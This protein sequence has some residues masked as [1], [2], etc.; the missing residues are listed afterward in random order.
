MDD[1][2]GRINL[3][4]ADRLRQLNARSNLAG[5]LQTSSHILAIAST[6][7]GLHLTWGTWWVVP[8]FIAHGILLNY[9]FAA[10]HEF[11]HYTA[12]RSRWVN[13]FFNR[14]TGFIL[15]YPRSYERWFHIEHHRH[16]QD[17]D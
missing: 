9:L 4:P 13:D 8:L 6:G 3:I 10:Q 7:T 11:N 15:L 16:T 12:F 17:W 1:F 14:I 2:V 5:A